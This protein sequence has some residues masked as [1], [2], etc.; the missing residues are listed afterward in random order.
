MLRDGV[1]DR[2]ASERMQVI[3]VSELVAKTM[4]R[5]QQIAAGSS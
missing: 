1:D 5:K 4:K 3:N 2:G